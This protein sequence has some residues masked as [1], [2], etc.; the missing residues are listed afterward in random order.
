M[1]NT[2]RVGKYL[3]AKLEDLARTYPQEIENLRGRDRGTFIAWDSPRRDEVLSLAKA[4][5]V[6]LGGSGKRAIRLRP[7]LI[8]EEH[9]GKHAYTWKDRRMISTDINDTADILVSALERTL[10]T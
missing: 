3:Y 4:Q 8:F 10:R 1:V 2:A 7:M 5:G 6:N 9:H